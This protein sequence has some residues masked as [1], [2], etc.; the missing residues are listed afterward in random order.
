MESP[1][2]QAK[3]QEITKHIVAGMECLSRHTTAC[4]REG[5][6]A[7]FDKIVYQPVLQRLNSLIAEAD[8]VAREAILRDGQLEELYGLLGRRMPFRHSVNS[9][10]VNTLPGF[11]LAFIDAQCKN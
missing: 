9:L 11:I 7:L 10:A 8:A 4:E 1:R 6:E 3:C 2:T 5:L